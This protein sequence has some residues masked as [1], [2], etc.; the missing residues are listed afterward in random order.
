M[1]RVKKIFINARFDARIAGD[2][3]R[4]VDGRH[5]G[6]QFPAGGDGH[7]AGERRQ[8]RRPKRRRRLPEHGRRRRHDDRQR[9][10]G[11]LRQHE[12]GHPRRD[13]LVGSL[14]V[15][16]PALDTPVVLADAAVARR[17]AG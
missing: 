12:R 5:A 1:F 8:R 6:L 13:P 2:Q 16:P 17:I 15:N 4:A 10:R 9:A 7:R 14:A 3:A 11:R